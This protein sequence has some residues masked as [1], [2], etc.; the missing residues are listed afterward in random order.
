MSAIEF[1]KIVEIAMKDSI[2][3]GAV[4]FFLFF[5]PSPYEVQNDPYIISAGGWVPFPI[6]IV[7]MMR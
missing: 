7:K 2:A 1:A 6:L 3:F 5:S 4:V